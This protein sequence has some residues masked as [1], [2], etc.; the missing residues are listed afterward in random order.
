MLCRFERRHADSFPDG[1]I[2]V[3]EFGIAD[4]RDLTSGEKAMAIASIA[5]PKFRDEFLRGVY[6]DPLFTKS[7][8]GYL[9]KTPNGVRM[10]EGGIQL[11]K[12]D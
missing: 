6:E 4:L 10:Y 1:V 11:A 3:T 5:H 9:D 2:I 8:G 7:I 12:N